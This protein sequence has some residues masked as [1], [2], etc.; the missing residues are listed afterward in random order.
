MIG[1]RLIPLLIDAGSEVTAVARTSSKAALLT[2]LGATP[3]T[4]DLFDPAAVEEAVAGHHTVIN[5]ATKIPSGMKVLLP[6][7]FNENIRIRREASQNL[8]AGAI[9]ARAQ[10][11]IQESFAPAYPDRG[12]EWI[13]ESVAIQPASYLESVKDA[14]SAADEFT[15]SGGAGVVLRFSMFYGPDSSLTVDIVKAIRNGIAPVF[16]G[17]DGYMSSLWTDDAATAVFSALKVPAGVYNVTDNE[18]MRR[19]EALSL[20]ASALGAKAPRMPPRWVTALSGSIGDTLGRSLRLSNAKFRQASGW[21]PTV[22]TV[23]MGWKVLID[24]MRALGTLPA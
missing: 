14:E 7:A 17:P 1:R 20:L 3:V 11:F 6:G 21:T 16:G 13:D 8:A 23:R 9:A 18:P 15:K 4:V 19:G 12:D 22:P 24:E 2:K 10:R 5:I